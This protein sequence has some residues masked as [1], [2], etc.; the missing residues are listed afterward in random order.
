[1]TDEDTARARF[2]CERC[3]PED[4]EAAWA[5]RRG[6]TC[7][8][9]LV[10]ESHFHVLILACGVCGQRF[11]SVFTETIDWTGGNDPQY[12]TVL[13][14]TREEAG[15]LAQGG[16]SGIETRLN[17]LGSGRRSLMHDFPRDGPARTEWGAGMLVGPHD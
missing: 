3:W 15:A 5:A 4:P 12:S 10:D 16:E 17:A 1:V 14:L 7:E 6:L 2:G 13:P 11:V 8:A 9:E